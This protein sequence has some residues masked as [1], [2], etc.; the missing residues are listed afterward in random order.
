MPVAVRRTARTPTSTRHRTP[1]SVR[2]SRSPYP[3]LSQDIGAFK[4]LSSVLSLPPAAA[5]GTVAGAGAVCYASPVSSTACASAA[6]LASRFCVRVSPGLR[7]F[8][9]VPGRAPPLQPPCKRPLPAMRYS[10]GEELRRA[11]DDGRRTKLDR[12]PKLTERPR[13]RISRSDDDSANR[14]APSERAS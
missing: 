11:T 13:V 7:F 14:T 12:W 5:A 9:P 1:L 6:C 4:N 8:G 2:V 10:G 3:S